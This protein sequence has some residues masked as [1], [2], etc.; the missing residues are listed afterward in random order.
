MKE[1]PE[2]IAALTKGE[3]EEQEGAISNFFLPNA[4]FSHPFCHVPSF[5]KSG[6][7]LAS[8]VDWLWVI[9]AVYRWYRTLN[10]HIDLKV[11][12][13]GTWSGRRQ[14]RHTLLDTDPCRI[15][16]EERTA[17]CVSATDVLPLVHPTLQGPGSPG[18]GAAAHAMQRQRTPRPARPFRAT[19]S[20]E[21]AAS[22]TVLHRQSGR[23]LPGKRQPPVSAPRAGTSSVLHVAALHSLALRGW[24]CDSVAAVPVT[25]KAPRPSRPRITC[26]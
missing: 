9:L 25:A 1:I 8:G 7:P 26:G 17:L 2:V 18:V 21:D 15:R 19:T 4:S 10:P 16:R 23:P 13:S 20:R 14:H 11:E 3:P 24:L 22:S 5:S 12:S 6:K